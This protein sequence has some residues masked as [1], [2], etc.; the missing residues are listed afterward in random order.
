MS[1]K[2]SSAVLERAVR[3][4]WHRV[5]LLANGLETHKALVSRV[6]G[7]AE[8]GTVRDEVVLARL[9]WFTSNTGHPRATLRDDR[10]YLHSVGRPRGT[11]TIRCKDHTHGPS[12]RLT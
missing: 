8:S 1:G 9:R 2:H 3:A 10:E 6:T 5:T 12:W 4:G 7:N 11:R